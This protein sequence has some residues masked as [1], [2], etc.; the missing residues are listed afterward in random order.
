MQSAAD[1]GDHLGR[2]RAASEVCGAKT[3]GER[4]LPVIELNEG[5]MRHLTCEHRL[6]VVPRAH[7]LFEEPGTL[8]IV[9]DLATR[10]FLSHFEESDNVRHVSRVS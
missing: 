10:W 1:V 4:D 5:A 3:I 8:D 2:R 7:H 9:V 6:S